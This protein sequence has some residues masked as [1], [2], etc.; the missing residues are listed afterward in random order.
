MKSLSLTET[1]NSEGVREQGAQ[2][3]TPKDFASRQPNAQY[4]GPSEFDIGRSM[5]G[6][7]C[8]MLL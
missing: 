3:P 4:D 8:F 2:R 5:F 6:V 7:R 1:P